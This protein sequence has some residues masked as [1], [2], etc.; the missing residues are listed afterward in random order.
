MAQTFTIAGKLTVPL[1][2]SVATAPID[3]GI[4]FTI[5]SRADF[6]RKYD[7]AVTDDPV[8]LGTLGTGPGAKGVLVKCINGA[9]TV[10]F[11]GATAAWP[12]SANGGFFLWSN[13]AQGFLTAA[14]IST[15]AAATVI[16]LAVG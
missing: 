12:L 1:E 3:L 15:T 14:L 2:D 6:S 11:N 4:T 5:T 10:K 9:C 8:N 13:G 7:S 16:F